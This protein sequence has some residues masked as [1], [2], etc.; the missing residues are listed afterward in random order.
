M[1]EE[2]PALRAKI[3]YTQDD[4]CDAVGISRQTYSSIETKKKTM[5]RNIFLSLIMFYSTNK[6]TSPIL[7]SI[8]AFP[9]AI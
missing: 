8:G 3:G 4:L 2:L 6:K 1:T 5:S 9:K 7:E